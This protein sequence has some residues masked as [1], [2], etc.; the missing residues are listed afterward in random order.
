MKYAHLEG[1]RLGNIKT[2]IPGC[3]R[4]CL[5]IIH[6][7]A[8]HV[9]PIKYIFRDILIEYRF[10][11]VILFWSVRPS[12]QASLV[13]LRSNHIKAISSSYEKFAQQTLY[14]TF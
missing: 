10:H 6:S 12:F 2:K 8:T 14:P 7:F 11:E 3:M 4:V 13:A 9:N 5:A 1:H